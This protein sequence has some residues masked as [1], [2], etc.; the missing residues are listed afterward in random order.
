MVTASATMGTPKRGTRPNRNYH[1]RLIYA[2]GGLGRESP[3]FRL[4]GPLITAT[5]V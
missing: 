2:L 1:V 5:A 4:H 3:N